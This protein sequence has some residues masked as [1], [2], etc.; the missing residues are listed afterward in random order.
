MKYYKDDGKESSNGTK[1]KEI[2]IEK[3]LEEI[4]ASLTTEGNF[5]GFSNDK[6][7]LFNFTKTKKMLG[8]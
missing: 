1:P 6:M 5:I 7:K 3:A 8:C 4:E 2:S